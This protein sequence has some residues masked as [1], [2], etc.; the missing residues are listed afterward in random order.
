VDR[1]AKT[2]ILGIVIGAVSVVLLDR[3]RQIREDQDP[4]ALVD[5]LADQMDALEQKLSK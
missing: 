4:E 1:G 2:L 5:R 3:L